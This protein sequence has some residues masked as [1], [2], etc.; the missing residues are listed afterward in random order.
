MADL[1]KGETA[2]IPSRQVL[3]QTTAHFSFATRPIGVERNGMPF[4]SA[5]AEGEKPFDGVGFVDQGIIAGVSAAGALDREANS[6]NVPT[7]RSDPGVVPLHHKPLSAF[8]TFQ[9]AKSSNCVRVAIDPRYEIN[10]IAATA[11][12]RLTQE[13]AVIQ[14]PRKD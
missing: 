5:D 10:T 12:V 2:I 7:I 14:V 1:Q 6:H 11:Q 8:F 13:S 9:L 3:S 4:P